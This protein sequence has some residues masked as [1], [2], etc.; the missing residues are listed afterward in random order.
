MLNAGNESERA[1]REGWPDLAVLVDCAAITCQRI[2]CTHVR[3]CWQ[4]HIARM[5]TPVEL[6]PLGEVVVA[7]S[8]LINLPIPSSC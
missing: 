8:V 5:T 1:T 2:Q 6:N 4:S 7:T 3:R